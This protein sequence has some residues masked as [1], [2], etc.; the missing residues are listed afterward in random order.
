MNPFLFY[1]AGAGPAGAFAAAGLGQ[2]GIPF[3]EDLSPAVTHLLLPVPSLTP[4]GLLRGGGDPEAL[5]ARSGRDVTVIGGGLDRPVFDAVRKLDL[6]QDPGYL[7]KNAAI[8]A[9]CALRLAEA[10]L[11]C[12][13]DGTPVLIVG[14]GRIGKHL[15]FRLR[16]RGAAVTVAARKER[17]RAM[18]ESFGIR[19][20]PTDR[21]PLA[22]C[23]VLF[24]TVPA[25]VLSEADAARCPPGCLKMELASV[26]GIGGTNVLQARGLPGRLAPEA[27]GA[28]IA[29]TVLKLLGGAF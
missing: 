9:D 11:P 16:Q 10:R 4:E 20:V 12:L 2:A 23:R 6:L 14:W 28:L 29:E 7:A 19:A 24:N 15:A 22:D 3:A 26:P 5:L 25:P 17:D 18:A 27:S 1:N 8:T 13:W 21:M